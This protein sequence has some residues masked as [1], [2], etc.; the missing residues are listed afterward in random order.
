MS[1]TSTIIA[2]FSEL[3]T[4]AVESNTRCEAS[5]PLTSKTRAP[6]LPAVLVGKKL[7]PNF[8]T[9]P[10]FA[11]PE[12]V[13]ELR[14]ADDNTVVGRVLSWLIE[15]ASTIIKKVVIQAD[16][17]KYQQKLVETKADAEEVK[18]L[19]VKL[20]KV[21]L[22][23]DE[24][25][26]RGMKGNLVLHSPA[27]TASDSI[28]MPKQKLRAG[29]ISDMES[30]AEACVRAIEA[31]TG[32]RVPLEDV[33]ACHP[34]GKKGAVPHTTF[35]IRLWNRKQHSAWEQLT[36]GLLTGRNAL[37]GNNF[38]SAPLYINYQLT[39]ARGEVVK[40]VREAKRGKRLHKYN[41]DANGRC[42]VQLVD[43]RSQWKEVKSEEDLKRLVASR[44]QQQQPSSQSRWGSQRQ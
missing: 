15:A 30:M 9:I 12:A 39:P 36:A 29:G 34:L 13:E 4:T 33:S 26:Q 2:K 8:S 41:V 7:G 22:E 11:N 35:I 42:F 38:T 3:I 40:V 18:R 5:S 37:T 31:K 27:T 44:H 25:R 1:F 14:G 19:Q 17:L 10:D 24:A 16:F 43:R 28:L 23:C 21:E 20:L 6:A 32:I